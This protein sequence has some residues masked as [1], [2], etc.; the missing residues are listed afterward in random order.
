MSKVRNDKDH[1]PGRQLLDRYVLVGKIGSGAVSDVYL[2]RQASVGNRN[3]AVKIIKKV[4]CTSTSEEAEV[5]RSRFKWEA[6]LMSMLRGACFARI[7]DVGILED[8]G[9]R[10]FVI[11]EYL[12][13]VIMEEHFKAGQKFPLSTATRLFLALA[14]AVVELHRYKVIYRDLSPG[15]VILEEG[16]A[17]GL[18]PRLFDF[19]HSAVPGIEQLEAKGATGQLLAGTPPYA[20]PELAL[21]GGD[22]RSDVFSLA[23]VFYALASGAPPLELHSTTW[24]DY[25]TA[26]S[27]LRSLP[28]KSLRS[29]GLKVPRRLDQVLA[30]ALAPRQDDRYPSVGLFVTDFCKAVL[31]SPALLLREGGDSLLLNLMSR[32]LVRD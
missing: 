21:G 27:G 32:F 17:Y 30:T 16:G 23:G 19:S 31:R 29:R 25:V 8:G 13:G 26:L 11:M 10:P 15:N 7:L 22:E 12:A 4:I 14:E 20:A 2:A 18:V 5:H 28:N 3:V 9:E 24:A 1:L 6:E